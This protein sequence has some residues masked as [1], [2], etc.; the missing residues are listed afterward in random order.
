VKRRIYL[1]TS[2]VQIENDVDELSKEF[3]NAGILKE[4]SFDDCRYKTDCKHKKS[5]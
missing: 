2:V 1:D 3:I 5:A 4:K